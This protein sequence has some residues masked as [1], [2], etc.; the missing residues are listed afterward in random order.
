MNGHSFIEG[1]LSYFYSLFQALEFIS[2]NY[3]QSYTKNV[4]EK[5]MNI[6]L[7]L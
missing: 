4:I 7:N 1:S 2:F 5:L 3:K 6:S